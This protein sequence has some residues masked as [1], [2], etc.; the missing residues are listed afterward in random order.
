M[1]KGLSPIYAR[2]LIIISF[3]CILDL[4]IRDKMIIIYDNASAMHVRSVHR[5]GRGQ[6]GK[7]SV[8]ALSVRMM[9]KLLTLI[10][11]SARK[12]AILNNT[13][14]TFRV[15]YTALPACT[16]YVRVRQDYREW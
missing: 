6:N 16:T 2:V 12:G 13:R 11:T 14:Y 15:L 4:S 3:V 7:F 10:R 8:Y 5:A 9:H 1:D